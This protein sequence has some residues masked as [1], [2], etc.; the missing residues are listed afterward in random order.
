MRIYITLFF[1]FVLLAIAF[2]FGS[3]NNQHITLNY[4]VAR[5][6]ITVAMA[7]SIFTSLGFILGLLTAFLWKLTRMV[8][9]KKKAVSAKGTS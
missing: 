9:P 7:V 3:Q 1:L 4:L 8:K 2:I 5:T 6:D